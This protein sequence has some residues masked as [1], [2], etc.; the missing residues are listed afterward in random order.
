MKD[1]MEMMDLLGSIAVAAVRGGGDWYI[2]WS[3]GH[4]VFSAIHLKTNCTGRHSQTASGCG[5]DF[6]SVFQKKK[7]L[8]KKEQPILHVWPRATSQDRRQ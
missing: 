4:H 6:V 3:K 7:K 5:V 8:S 1:R 2:C